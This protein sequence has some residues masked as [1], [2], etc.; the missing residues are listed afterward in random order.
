MAILRSEQL[1]EPPA[2]KKKLP[3][4]L[5]LLDLP[6]IQKGTRTVGIMVF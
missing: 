2:K 3:T 6:H 5:M 4:K 1:V